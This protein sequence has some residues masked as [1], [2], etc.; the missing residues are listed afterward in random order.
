MA[1][2]CIIKQYT[3]EYQDCVPLEL[4]N[5]T[6]NKPQVHDLPENYQLYSPKHF[7]DLI[8]LSKKQMMLQTM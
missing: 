1:G 2:S 3:L 4:L 6:T 8:I 5:M 7:K